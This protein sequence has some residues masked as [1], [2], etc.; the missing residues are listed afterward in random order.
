MSETLLS[1]LLREDWSWDPMGANQITF[2]NDGTGRLVCR[3]ELNVWIAAEF[4]WKPQSPESLDTVIDISSNTPNDPH[5][6]SQFDIEL[7]LTKRR[8]PKLGTAE[9]HSYRIN[10]SLL[11]DDAFLPKTYTVR[12]EK[13]EFIT[14]YDAMSTEEIPNA[15]TFALRLVFDKSPYP[16]RDEWKTPEGA[17]DAIKFWEWKEFCGRRLPGGRGLNMGKGKNLLSKILAKIGW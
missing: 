9:M 10:E 11:T 7:T 15:S 8:I 16:P 12:L 5:L 1:I 2:N 17:P 14:S 3:H 4:D 6:I 13:G